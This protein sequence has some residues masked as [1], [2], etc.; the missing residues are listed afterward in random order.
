MRDFVEAGFDV[1][2]DDPLIRAGR[3]VM[4]LGHRVMSSAIRAKPIGAREKIRL[5]NWLQHQF[6]AGLG[7]P[8]ADHSNPQIADFAARFRDRAL[9]RRQRLQNCGLSTKP[10]TRPKTPRP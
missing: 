1:S 9:L 3:E 5:E 10:A 2:F 4:D 6:N 7:Y 8:V